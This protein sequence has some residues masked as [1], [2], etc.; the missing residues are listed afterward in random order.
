MRRIA[1]ALVCLVALVVGTPSLASAAEPFVL[2]EVNPQLHGLDTSREHNASLR[3]RFVRIQAAALG[4]KV[5]LNLFDDLSVTAERMATRRQ[6]ESTV[7]TGRVVDDPE[8]WVIVATHDNG[9]TFAKVVVDGSIFEVRP[10]ARGVH[11]IVELDPAAT[12]GAGASEEPLDD[13]VVPDFGFDA[14]GGD[15]TIQSSHSVCDDAFGCGAQTIDIM[16]VYTSAARNAMGGTD[17]SAQATIAAGVD[18]M[19]LAMS[20]TGVAH[21]YNLVHTALVAYTESGNASTDLTRL[22]SQTD[23]FMDEVHPWRDQHAADLVSLITASGGCGIGYVAIDPVNFSD[24]WGFNCVRVDCLTGN[25]TLAHEVGHNMGLQHDWYVSTDDRPCDWH[26]GYVNQAAFGGT[27]SQR[28]R[29]VMAYNTQ[30]SDSGFNCTRLPYFSNPDNLRDGDPMGVTRG[31]AQASDAAYALTRTACKVAAYRNGGPVAPH[32]SFTASPT[33]GNAP[34]AVTFDASGSSDDGTITSYVWDFGDGANGSGVTTNHTYALHGTYTV[35]LTVTDDEGLDDTATQS[36]TALDPSAPVDHVAVA[37]QWVSGSVS[38][39]YTDTHTNNGISES[40]TEATNGGK[41]ANRESFMEILWRFDITSGGPATFHTNAWAPTSGDGDAFELAFSTDGSSYQT[42]LTLAATLDDDVYQTYPLGTL[43]NTSVWVRLRDTVREPGNNVEDRVWVDHMFIRTQGGAAVPAAPSDLAAQVASDSQIDLTW[44]D[45]AN[46]EDG[47]HVERSVDGGA[48][49]LLTSLGADVTGYSDM[50]LASFT[51]YAYRVQ[52]FNADGASAYS[53]VASATTSGTGPVV[54]VGDLTG[55]ANSAGSRWS[56]TTVVTVHD[57]AHAPVAGAT[58][59]ADWAGG[60][61]GSD[62][63]TTDANG[64]AS[65]S[66]SGLKKGVKSIQFEVTDIQVAG[67]NYAPGAND[68][69]AS[70]VIQQPSNDR[71]VAD[72]VAKA[73]IP[74]RLTLEPNHPNPFN[75][76]TTIRY[77]L[78]AAGHVH[79]VVYDMLGRHVRTLVDAPQAAG[80]HAARW[81]G[82]DARGGRVASGVY[83]YRLRAGGI[84]IAKRMLLMK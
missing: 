39:T 13:A 8:S 70:I 48:W 43:S 6:L 7:W 68:V 60:A 42:M 61:Q 23:G 17:A 75:P 63:V 45:N 38:G 10:R 27:S 37:E 36:I 64:N 73:L 54:H 69:S 55:S 49:S 59:H 76:R 66:K 40:V 46:D 32:A 62:T 57:A 44:T 83:I 79:L 26:H 33:T 52:A 15:G 41:P 84:E 81:D 35:T 3:Y 22:R 72:I 20:N 4:A 53:S 12:P 65:F 77:G 25:L 21:T 19:N 1:R 82:L 31:S 30:C 80:T 50:G 14:R 56:A 18:E 29:T 16:I 24:T 71:L 34:L 78:P 74:S 5:T 11:A 51:T 9:A 58:V 67:G 28:W 2:D 47:F